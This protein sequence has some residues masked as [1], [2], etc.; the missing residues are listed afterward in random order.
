[1]ILRLCE[2]AFPSSRH[3]HPYRYLIKMRLATNLSGLP[4]F[5]FLR[6]FFVFGGLDESET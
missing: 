2:I 4:F 3:G 5:F 1:M 6:I